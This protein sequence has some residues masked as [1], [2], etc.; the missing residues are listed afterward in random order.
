VSCVLRAIGQ[1][2]DPAAFLEQSDLPGATAFHRGD[3]DIP[4]ALGSR[5]R[6][7]SGFNVT[8]SRA[9]FDDLDAQIRDAVRFLRL[10]EDELRRLSGF[11][12][13]DEVCLDFGLRR[14]DAPART[15]LFPAEL[16]WQAGA[17]DIDLVVT[18]YAVADE[19]PLTPN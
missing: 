3:A 18:H 16:L 11:D 5:R 10:H 8:V 2:F 14:S 6:T 4:G 9:G 1:E 12:G 17:L 19:P 15:Y 7:A 13:V